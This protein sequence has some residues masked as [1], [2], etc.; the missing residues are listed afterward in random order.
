MHALAGSEN[1]SISGREYTLLWGEG[2][3]KW[4]IGSNWAKNIFDVIQMSLLRTFRGKSHPLR[5]PLTSCSYQLNNHQNLSD[6][7]FEKT[8]ESDQPLL[9]EVM[10]GTG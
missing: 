9:S 2:Y 1:I 6:G 5:I 10:V 4:E 3:G 8:I 7:T